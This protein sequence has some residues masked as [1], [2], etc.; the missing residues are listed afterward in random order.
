MGYSILERKSG[1]VVE[2]FIIYILSFTQRNLCYWGKMSFAD[3][4]ISFQ[5]KSI[6]M[7]LLWYKENEQF[8]FLFLFFFAPT[9]DGSVGKVWALHLTHLGLSPVANNLSLVG[10]HKGW[11][12]G[13]NLSALH[14][15]WRNLA[16]SHFS[17]TKK[18]KKKTL[19]F[20]IWYYQ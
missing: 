9:E 8:L 6:A 14:G 12:T 18:K 1:I 7:E 20:A 17:L 2:L 3:I 19:F 15:G 5:R 4:H 11:P 10:I 16:N 13:L